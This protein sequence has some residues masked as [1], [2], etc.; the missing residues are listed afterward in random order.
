MVLTCLQAN[1]SFS[2]KYTPGASNSIA[3]ALSHFQED[4]F[5]QLAL[6]TDSRP[7]EF[8]EELWSLAATSHTRGHGVHHPLCGKGLRAGDEGISIIC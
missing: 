8:P 1:K 3:D 2:V 6:M 5:Q 4:R 7:E